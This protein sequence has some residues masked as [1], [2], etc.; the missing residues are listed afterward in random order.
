MYKQ[1]CENLIEIEGAIS[2]VQADLRRYISL[3]K[4]NFA[5]KYTKILSYLITCW[6]EVRILKLSYECN[7]FNPSESEIESII[8]SGTLE[9]KWISALNISI[10]K[11]YDINL[12]PDIENQLTFTARARYKEL[13]ALIETD[14]APSIE[15]RNRIAHGQWKVAFTSDLKSISSPLTGKLRTENIVTLQL[16]KKLLVGLASLI[17]DLAVSSLTFERDFDKNYRVIEENKR[18]LHKR[19]YNTYKANMIAKYQRG[20]AKRNNL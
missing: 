2:L 17:H 8:T 11:A 15:I 10:S 14:L 6:T 4:D 18:N 19:D 1:H 13:K 16:K 20:L 9:N 5:Y 3:G 7:A 12:G